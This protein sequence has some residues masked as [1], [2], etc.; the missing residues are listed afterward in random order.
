MGCAR[1]SSPWAVI[2]TTALMLGLEWLR[3]RRLTGK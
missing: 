3:G 2:F 1:Q